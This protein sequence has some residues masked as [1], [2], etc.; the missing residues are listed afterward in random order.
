MCGIAGFSGCDDRAP[1]EDTSA[2]MAH[3]EIVALDDARRLAGTL[4]ESEAHRA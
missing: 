4:R 3:R 2:A 1:L